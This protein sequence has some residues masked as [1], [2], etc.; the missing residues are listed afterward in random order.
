MLVF[1]KVTVDPVSASLRLLLFDWFDHF[2]LVY[3]NAYKMELSLFILPREFTVL[4]SYYC[5]L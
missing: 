2:L 5:Y 1:P 3:I 4:P